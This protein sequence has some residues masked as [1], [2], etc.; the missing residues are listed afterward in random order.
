M[1]IINTF[2]FE[3]DIAETEWTFLRAVQKSRI[4]PIS[5]TSW[6]AAA[7]FLKHI[8]LR[9]G[10]SCSQNTSIY[11]KEKFTREGN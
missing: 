3:F 2:H 1:G 4:L 10:T 7:E 5:H 11:A 6:D 8:E 9:K